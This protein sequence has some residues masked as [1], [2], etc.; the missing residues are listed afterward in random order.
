MDY[1]R[2]GRSGLK[3]SRICQGTNMFGAGYVDGEQSNRGL[4]RTNRPGD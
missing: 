4:Q 1:V 3:V 2:V